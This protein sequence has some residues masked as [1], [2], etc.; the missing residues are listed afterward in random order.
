LGEPQFFK[1][2]YQNYLLQNS[3][4]YPY[5][6]KYGIP[7]GKYN[8]STNKPIKNPN[9]A[10]ALQNNIA[11][12]INNDTIPFTMVPLSSNQFKLTASVSR[13]YYGDEGFLVVKNPGLI[14]SGA[15]A[16][17]LTNVS[18]S[19]YI[20]D[21]N[22]PSYVNA[23]KSIYDSNSI[24]VQ[25]LWG[26]GKYPLFIGF[27]WVFMPLMLVMQ[28]IM[29]LNYIDS[30]KPLN[31]NSFLSSFADF[32]NPSIFYNPVRNNI[33]NSVVSHDGMYLN[34]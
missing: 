28:Y 7:Y 16:T 21:C 20:Y 8:V 19:V 31:L 18:Q 32:R 17:Q 13:S 14:R 12:T 10:D 9:F 11:L 27:G 33:D 6:D 2:L 3:Y 22:I 23:A 26:L 15:T 29:S 4:T 34:L 24:I 1:Y 30:T 5:Y 25:V